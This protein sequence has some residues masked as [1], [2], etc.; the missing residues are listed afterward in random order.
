MSITL[1]GLDEA[2]KMLSDF[3][4]MDGRA[5]GALVRSINMVAEE[6]RNLAIEEITKQVALTPGY[7]RY[8]LEIIKKAS[9]DDPTAIISARVR[10]T[11]LLR[12]QGKQLYTK[13]KLPGKRRLAGV[14]VQVKSSARGGY[15]KVITNGWIIKL[16]AGRSKDS[17]GSNLGIAT[18]E[19]PGRD[20]YRIRYAPSVDQVWS[21]VRE[22]VKPLI[23]PRLAAEFLKQLG[24][25]S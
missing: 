7:V 2:I 25:T 15:P 17:I 18:R 21:D 10:P 6:T 22:D 5:R 14:S 1:T 24:I 9:G 20:N 12:Y 11:Q 19:G 3:D 16:K 13:A 23:E 4:G 8:R